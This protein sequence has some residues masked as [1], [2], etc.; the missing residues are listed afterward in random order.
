MTID[1]TVR[2]SI[3]TVSPTITL[4]LSFP[5]ECCTSKPVT[6]GNPSQGSVNLHAI[7]RGAMQEHGFLVDFPPEA[8]REAT[9]AA[10]PDFSR[11]QVKDL[12][13][14]LWSSIDNDDSRD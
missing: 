4:F 3:S 11:L 10:E 1:S 9:Q 12:S 2:K 6:M 5:P 13:G 7:A 8:T 14:W